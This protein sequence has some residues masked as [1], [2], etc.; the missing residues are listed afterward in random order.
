MGR[1]RADPWRIAPTALAAALAAA[2]LAW[3]PPSLD[4]AAADYRAWLF[5]HAGW[6][7]W[8]NG[9]YG[10]HH[11]PGY[12]VLF[13]PLGWWLGVRLAGAL[14]VVASAV[15]FER[16]AWAR[17]GFR[18]RVGA[19]WFA[20]G[21]A[22]TLLSG[23][24]TFALGLVFALGALVALQR[25]SSDVA[26]GGSWRRGSVSARSVAF[27]GGAAETLSPRRPPER[28][29]L[30]TPAHGWLLLA[31]ALAVLTPL[32][33]PVAALFLALAGVAYALAARRTVGLGLA[34]CAL[35]PIGLFAIAFPEGGSE[36]FAFSSFWPTVAFAAVA[37]VLLPRDERGLRVGVALYAAAC[38]AAYVLATPVGGNVVRLGALC[39]GPVLALAL[40]RR[41]MVALA[42]VALP[43]LWWQ[44]SAAIDDVRVASG[45]PS[46]GA[47]YYAPLLAA[48]AREG[49]PPGRIE[50]PFTRLHW[51]ARW[52]AP[53]VPLARGW[54]R[55]LD[56]RDDALFYGATLTPARYR[57][58]LDRLAVRWVALPDVRL[59]YSAR[60]EARL[61]RAGLPYLHEVWHGAH[62]R[63]L[64]VADPAPLAAPPARVTQLGTDT[65]TL[66]APRAGTIALRVRWTPYW[67]VTR[68]DACVAP[69]GDWTQLRVRHPGTIRLAT[70]FSLA[71][72]R[73][74]TP[75]CG[76]A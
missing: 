53:Q 70:R 71:R 60:Q 66:T 58:W 69:A 35:L 40:W 44:W 52:V 68:G 22:T 25:G 50:I 57:A 36:P 15:L 64:A 19:L 5:G 27:A 34:V 56:R 14:A 4:L 63:L 13:P 65:V 72:I 48:V 46:V 61:I 47:A 67:A 26:A 10:G 6:A 17:Y 20:A 32:A 11:L 62:W 3:Q 24:L 31:L 74:R 38:V 76:H 2:Y 51:E 39:G 75:R 73:S 18:A 9:W 28:A 37:V 30:L 29:S 12:S 7:V 33:S 49:G 8:D 23:R 43:L 21:A 42:L 1:P 41:R 16:L 55:Q 59:D 45:D 54:E